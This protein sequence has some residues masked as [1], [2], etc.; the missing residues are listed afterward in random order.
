MFPPKY[1]KLREMTEEELI[2]RYDELA[3]NTAVGLDFVLN[4]LVRRQQ[5][6]Q[7]DAMMHQSD[8]MLRY[9]KWIVWM[10]IIVTVATLINLYIAWYMMHKP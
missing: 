8:V 5:S 3:Q 9:T 7:T 10:T 1:L 4:E 2:R 6:K